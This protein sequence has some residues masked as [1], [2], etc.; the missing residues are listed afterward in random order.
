MIYFILG[1]KQDEDWMIEFILFIRFQNEFIYSNQIVYH[2]AFHRLPTRRNWNALLLFWIRNHLRQWAFTAS[3]SA[4]RPWS[5]VV[6][7]RVAFSAPEGRKGRPTDTDW[8]QC[9]LRYNPDLNV[10]F[11][12]LG[13]ID[14][15]TDWSRS[16]GVLRTNI[17]RFKMEECG[18]CNNYFILA[19]VLVPIPCK[20]WNIWK[21]LLELVMGY[22]ISLDSVVGKI[23]KCAFSYFIR[24][25][26]TASF[27]G[28]LP[29]TEWMILWNWNLKFL[30]LPTD[31]CF[32]RHNLIHR[33]AD[34]DLRYKNNISST[35]LNSIFYL[36]Y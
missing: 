9:T 1:R 11:I 28:G 23:R 34:F 17:F 33:F 20:F 24:R 8:H 21:V 18:R 32:V 15:L 26:Y 19:S 35:K 4:V 12:V 13:K 31:K 6:I 3:L 36:V 10:N 2:W 22:L 5:E 7:L 14:S 27:Y 30:W 29:E 25:L 16:E